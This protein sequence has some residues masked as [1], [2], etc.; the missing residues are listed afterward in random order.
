MLK[1]CQDIRRIG[2][3]FVDNIVEPTHIFIKMS[4]GKKRFYNDESTD[5]N[6]LLNSHVS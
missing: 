3:I 2:G 5:P 4:N 6:A 1:E